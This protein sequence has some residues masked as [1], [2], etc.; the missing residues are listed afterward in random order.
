MPVPDPRFDWL[1]ELP[2]TP[3]P[4]DL[5]MGL[6]A[7]A[8]ERWLLPDEL[9]ESELRLRTE[10]LAVHGATMVRALPGADPSVLEL[11]SAVAEL[12]GDP[13][14]DRD[15]STVDHLLALGRAV[16]E[17]LYVLVPGERD[18]GARWTLVAGVSVFANQFQLDRILGGSLAMIHDPIDG[19]DEL[20]A[21][22]V[23]AF[24]D[25]L[26]VGRMAWRRN[27][28]LHDVADYYQPDPAEPVAIDDPAAAAG[29]YL[30]SEYET[31]R[32]LPRTGA[33]VFTVKTQIAPFTEVAARPEVAA[34][35]AAYLDAASP[36][37]LAGKDAQGRHHAVIEF[38]RGAVAST[39]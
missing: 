30:R 25:N 3:G 27:W 37:A 14:P 10:L 35:V 2:L 13:A 23:D 36:R 31:L 8:P 11:A 39:P 12:K 32:K 17:D 15:H 19:Y 28:F 16:P 24:F 34:G 21:G 38:L 22:R 6:R 5:R 7:L 18:D 26:A 33:V 9:T 1:L 29:L 20:L 4:P